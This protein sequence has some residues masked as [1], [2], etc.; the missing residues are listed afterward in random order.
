MTNAE[1]ID[2]SESLNYEPF[3]IGMYARIRP[4]NV[5]DLNGFTDKKCPFRRGIVENIENNG[6][7]A[8]VLCLNSDSECLYTEEKDATKE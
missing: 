5:K 6:K 3:T 8:Y 7:I 4:H 1:N 2:S